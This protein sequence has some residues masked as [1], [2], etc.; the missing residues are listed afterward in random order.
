MSQLSRLM[1]VSSTVV[2]QV[3]LTMGG[4][5]ING[6]L[7]SMLFEVTPFLRGIA[8]DLSERLGPSSEGLL[9]TI[10]V[11]F[12]L[13]SLVIGLVF[14]LMSIARSGRLLEY[15]PRTVLTGAVGTLRLVVGP[16]LLIS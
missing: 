2:S 11:A 12:S 4:S 16:T 3:T 10:M 6:V 7:G 8:S 5:E 15:I 14:T 9:P 13:C 1:E